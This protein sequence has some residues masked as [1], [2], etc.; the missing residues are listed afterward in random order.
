MIVAI[1]ILLAA[2]VISVLLEAECSE[3]RFWSIAKMVIL[4]P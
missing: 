2:N 1:H 3:Q 4:I